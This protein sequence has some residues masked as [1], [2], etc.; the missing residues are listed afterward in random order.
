[1]MGI[2]PKKHHYVPQSVLTKFSIGGAGKQI[3]VFDKLEDRLWQ[4]AIRDA[5]SENR[6]NT[7]EIDGEQISF[8]DAFRD[9][10]SRLATLLDRLS[11]ER[12][13]ATLAPADWLDLADVVA[14][15][16]VRTKPV[17]SALRAVVE[18]FVSA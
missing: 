15:Q 4:S 9:V 2:A 18:G 3:Y 7:L 1:M 6:F 5:G 12:S 10:D 16:L 14:G 13:L 17:R 8:E 11:I